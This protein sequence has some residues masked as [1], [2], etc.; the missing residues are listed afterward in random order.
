MDKV[1]KTLIKRDGISFDEA[2]R[3]VDETAKELFKLAE[4]GGSIY[5]AYDL[6]HE[7]LGLEGDY[8]EDLIL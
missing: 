7:N 3:L 2:Y 6:I 8:L 1:I 4:S 5:D